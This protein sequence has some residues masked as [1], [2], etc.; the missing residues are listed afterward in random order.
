[1][2]R[3]EQPT[4]DGG[5][6]HSTRRIMAQLMSLS[7]LVWNEQEINQ[8]QD[9]YVNVGQMCAA[10]G[11]LLSNW[12]QLKSASEYLEGLSEDIGIPIS[13]LMIVEN[14]KPTYAHPLIAIELARWISVPFSLW[15]NRNI[16]SMIE[17][18]AIGFPIAQQSPHLLALE[19]SDAIAK[20]EDNLSHNPRLCQVLIDHAMNSVVET[21]LLSTSSETQ[22]RGVVEIAVDMGYKQATNPSVRTKLGK[23]VARQFAPQKEKRLVN[24]ILTDINC[25][26]DSKEIR[27]AI[28]VYFDN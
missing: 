9:G 4:C 7:S 24:G 28:A 23:F 26:P 21:K 20:I 16:K 22:L 5:R 19:V 8:R 11:K 1:M 13:Q 6:Y 12:T 27:N 10:N 2:L 15:C 25:Y 18:R 17:S 14:G 3:L